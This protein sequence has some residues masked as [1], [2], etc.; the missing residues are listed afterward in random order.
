MINALCGG[1]NRALVIR[2]IICHAV[3]RLTDNLRDSWRDEMSLSSITITS[4]RNHVARGRRV[5]W[6]IVPT[7]AL[8]EVRQLVQKW[9]WPPLINEARSDWQYGQVGIP[10][11]RTLFNSSRASGSFSIMSIWSSTRFMLPYDIATW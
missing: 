1:S 3:F 10:C 2:P 5:R 6:N 8:N 7:V 4:A 11:Q 9:R